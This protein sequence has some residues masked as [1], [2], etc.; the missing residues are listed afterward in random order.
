MEERMYKGRIQIKSSSKWLYKCNHEGCQS[1]AISGFDKCVTH[2]GGKRCSEEGCQSSA[3]GGYDKCKAHGGGKRCSVEGCKT[4]AQSGYDKCIAHGGGKRCIHE[5]CQKSATDGT[6]KCIKHG[7]G[8]RCTHEGCQK[9]AISG[10]DKC[11]AHGGGKRCTHEGC[12]NSAQSG[13]DKCIAH[14]GGKRCTYEG[15]QKSARG[16]TDKCKAHGGGERCPICIDWID[17]RSGCKK[18]DGHCATCFK[19]FF[20]ND[21]RS[22]KI[23]EKSKEIKVRNKINDHFPEFI[24]DKPL[25]TTNCDCTNRRRIDHRRLIGNTMLAIE[26]D[27]FGHRSYDPNDE[28]IRYDDLY[29]LYSGKWIWIRFNPDPNKEAKKTTFEFKLD[30]LIKEIEKQINRINNEENKDLVEIIKMYL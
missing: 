24:H 10:T 12:Q 28:E 5:G 27:E 14:G 9:S 4:A 17:S 3:R 30:N 26:T 25:Y 2:G 16:G 18:Y 1:I 11:I 7:G 19:R 15:C 6:D 8:K 21:P 29:M 13:T 23:Y 22:Q 20:P